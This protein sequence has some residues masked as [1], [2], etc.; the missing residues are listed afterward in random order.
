MS[1]LDVSTGVKLWSDVI[2]LLQGRFDSLLTND[3][4]KAGTGVSQDSSCLAQKARGSHF[5]RVILEHA[6]NIL[7]HE[8][9][10]WRTKS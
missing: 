1:V 3:R 8:R 4:L 5:R 7:P 10:R 2:M 9:L 6:G